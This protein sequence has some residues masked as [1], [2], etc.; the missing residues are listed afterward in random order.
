[1]RGVKDQWIEE[2]TG[3]LDAKLIEAQLGASIA[4]VVVAAFGMYGISSNARP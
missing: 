1:M 2:M 4:S 3:S